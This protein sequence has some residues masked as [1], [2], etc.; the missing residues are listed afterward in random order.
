[1]EHHMPMMSIVN[2]IQS[3]VLDSAVNKLNS[4]LILVYDAV[5]IAITLLIICAT[6]LLL[7]LALLAYKTFF[8]TE[9]QLRSKPGINIQ[10][11]K[12]TPIP[13][14]PWTWEGK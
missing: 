1:M 10:A 11:G 2:Q 8:K 13:R 4:N 9:Q 5:W 14:E 6:L 3:P 7:V 12:K